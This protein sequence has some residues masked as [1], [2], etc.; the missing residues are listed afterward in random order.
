M[1]LKSGK[2]DRAQEH[3]TICLKIKIGYLEKIRD[4]SGIGRLEGTKEI[5]YREGAVS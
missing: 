2:G 3:Q 5:I 1:K 4:V